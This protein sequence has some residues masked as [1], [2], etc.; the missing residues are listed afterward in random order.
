M[1]NNNKSKTH[2]VLLNNIFM[3]RSKNFSIFSVNCKEPEDKQFGAV[4]N[5]KWTGMVG[6]II[7]ERAQIIVAGLDHTYARS[8]VVDFCFALRDIGLDS[9]AYITQDKLLFFSSKG[10][11]PKI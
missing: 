5:G 6:D 10:V 8:Q 7:E 1:F 4:K 3:L 11:F 9:W 2:F